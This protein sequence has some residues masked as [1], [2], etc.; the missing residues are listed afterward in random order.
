MKKFV[1]LWICALGVCLVGCS[2]DDTPEQLPDPELTLAPD[3]PI[4]FP[5]KGGNVEIA[6]TTNME[7]WSAVS[8][9]EWCKVA[10]SAGKFTV[11][12]V[13]NETLAPMPAATVTVTAS[14]GERS[15]SRKLQVSQEAGKEKIVDLSE[16]GTSNCYL[17]TAA[18]NYSFDAT[19]RGNGATTE[20]LDAPTAIA[21][22]SAAVVWQSAPGLISGVT[23]A[24]GRISFKIAGPGNAVIAVKDGAILWSWHIW[25]PEAEVA[26]LNSKTGY[27]VMNMNLGAMHNTPGDVGS[28]GLL[29]QWGRKDPFPAAPTLTGTTATVGAP[30]Y[31]GDNNEIK[32]TN[33]SQSSTADNNLA[34]AIANPT[35]CLSNYAQFSTS[36]DWLQA[37]ASNDALWGNPKGAERNETNDFLN[38]GAKSFYDPC[39][40]GWRVPPAD[41]FRNFTASGGYA[42]VIDDFD[43]A[44]ISGDGAKSLADSERQRIFLLPRSGA[45]RRLLRHADGQHERLVG[46]LLG[47]RTLP[48]RQVPGRGL[49]GALV[50]D[51][52]HGRQ[53]DDYH[54]ARRRRCP[55]RR[56]LGALH[57]RINL[58]DAFTTESG[59]ECRL[60]IPF[61]GRATCRERTDARS[62]RRRGICA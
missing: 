30:I 5:A 15:V 54:L 43:I 20:G 2:D 6:V 12:A 22:T 59:A 33:S 21:G 56:L 16:A 62:P 52:G 28:Y 8:D 23:L 4:A 61:A 60:P 42:W 45:L 7:T 34:F 18:G 44:D 58:S 36:R 35:V 57:P 10:A 25:Y 29:Y 13:E 47:Q 24:D 32:I 50:P 55:R 46:F 53:R 31:D 48:R 1:L 38:K 11:S 26:G 9:Q 49:L 27:E 19:V 37:D 51:Q 40:I 3:A 41:V 14:T 39:P 17:V